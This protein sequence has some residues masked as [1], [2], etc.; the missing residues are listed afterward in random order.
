M[1]QDT[2]AHLIASM[3]AP[4]RIAVTI[5]VILA[6]AFLLASVLAPDAAAACGLIGGGC[7]GG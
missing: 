3:P 4:A 2:F 7:S 5:Q 1:K 6:L